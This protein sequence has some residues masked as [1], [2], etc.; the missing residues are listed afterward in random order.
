M[1]AVNIAKISEKFIKLVW[2]RE[3]DIQGGY[4][5]PVYLHRVNI[6]VDKAGFPIAWQHT[7]VG[8]SLFVNTP[9]EKDI[10]SNGIDWSSVTTGSPYSDSIPDKTFELITTKTGVPVLA[11][12]AVGNT[13]TAFVVETLIDELATLAKIEPV[14]Y[15]RTLLKNNSRHLSALNLA[16]EKAAWD[17]PLPPGRFRGVAVHEAMGSYV[18]QVVEISIENKEIK[19]HRVICAIDCG[20]A[21]N[22]DGVIAQIEGGIIF[23][24]TAALYGEISIEKGLV[25]QSNFHDYRMLRMNEAPKIEVYIV[26]SSEK[27]GGAGEPGV[28]PIAPALANAIFS[29]TGQRLRN[30]PLRL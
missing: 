15:R 20:I 10:V 25:Q 3:D 26:P 18:S 28:P 14:E 13:H 1:E 7:I 29:A 27:M 24:L 30:L 22:P 6:G 17:K 11:W 2:T 5:R 9:L 4:Y 23:G 19:V 16:V 12:R 8:Q 21:V